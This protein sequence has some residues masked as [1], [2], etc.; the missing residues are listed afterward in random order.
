MPYRKKDISIKM[1]LGGNTE[2]RVRK[3]M[4]GHWIVASDLDT[5]TTISVFQ[6]L[7][8]QP[9][10]TFPAESIDILKDKLL[11]QLNKNHEQSI[12]Q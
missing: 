4:I 7:D 8:F 3:K 9:F 6:P 10:P 1:K 12:T 5:L 11:D 2:V